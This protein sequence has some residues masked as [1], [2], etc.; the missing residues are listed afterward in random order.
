MKRFLTFVLI[1]SLLITS[2]A[3]SGADGGTSEVDF[4]RVEELLQGT[5]EYRGEI[6]G[7]N[8]IQKVEFNNKAL[9]FEMIFEGYES[10]ASTY[11]GTYSVDENG[12]KLDFDENFIYLMYSISG[13]T[14]SLSMQ[15]SSETGD[16]TVAQFAKTSKL[17]HDISA[18]AGVPGNNGESSHLTQIE[19]GAPED[20]EDDKDKFHC[21]TLDAGYDHFTAVLEDGHV[22]AL[23]DVNVEAG[24]DD[25]ELNVSEWENI[26]S[27]A[28]GYGFTMG[29]RADGTV[30]GTG[31]ERYSNIVDGVKGWE[32]IISIASGAGHIVGLQA[33]GR[34][35]AAGRGDEGQL[36]VS[37]W[38]DI[39]EIAA[40]GWCTLGL[41][42]DGTVVACGSNEYGQCNVDGWNDIVDI[43]GNDWSSFGVRA[44]GTV[45]YTG[46]HDSMEKSKLNRLE[47]WFDIAAI[48][49]YRDTDVFGI[50]SDGTILSLNERIPSNT[51]GMDVA[52][53]G[54]H[55][56][57][58]YVSPYGTLKSTSWQLESDIEDALQGRRLQIPTLHKRTNT[59]TDELSQDT[60]VWTITPYVDE[61]NLPTDEYFIVN[62][63]PFNGTFSNSATTNSTLSAFLFYEG[64]EKYDLLSIRL[65]E[66]G[67]HRVKNPYSKSRDY[68]IVVMDSD[69]NK[70]NA[71]GTMFANSYDV[72][73]TDEQPI[74][75]AL[76]KGGTVR[77]AITEK[78]DPLTKYIITIDDATGFDV[79]YRQFWSK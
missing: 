50:R 54:Y 41:R 21:N 65:L 56:T 77:L 42:S 53:S 58:L 61:F 78:E 46:G 18:T 69:G 6:D 10:F 39:I 31:E 9:Y 75:N 37:G 15:I 66:Y 4:D 17:T 20:L 43:E 52:F 35:V 16:A 70:T 48:K 59:D 55:N 60:G 73:V 79:A 22:I 8:F 63:M 62:E 71:E 72:S 28:T 74:L 13:N 32:N 5:W 76:K 3:A 57:T 68:K 64:T 38:T 36:E 51:L 49:A 24:G 14:L 33:D 19:S 1:C 26:V 40:G 12:V 34:V 7:I 23:Y 27:V 25:G 67:N 11:E 2:A 45:V 29:L 47:R 44:D 30:I